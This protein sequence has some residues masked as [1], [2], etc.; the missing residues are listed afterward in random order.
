MREPDAAADHDPRWIDDQLQGAQQHRDPLARRSD[1][2][3]GPFG[4]ARRGGEDLGGR[5]WMTR[6]GCGSLD[7]PA[8]A[9]ILRGSAIA[10]LHVGDLADA[11]GNAAEQPAAGDDAAAD[12]GRDRHEHHVPA[13][14]SAEAVLAPGGRLGVVGGGDRSMEDRSQ[15]RRQRVAVR[16]GQGRGI[17]RMP[18]ALVEDAGGSDADNADAIQPGSRQLADSLHQVIRLARARRRHSPLV[19]NLG[20]SHQCCQDLGAA[21]IDGQNRLAHRPA[22]PAIAAANHE[23][24]CSGRVI[25]EPTTTAKAP[26]SSAEAACSG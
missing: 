9:V 25:A 24:M 17:E 2:R 3:L 20:A 14:A 18:A 11:A 21:D 10:R 26:A 8:G 12:A 16:N 5:A 6:P 15:P 4:T 1:D 13:F 19:Q 7:P 22:A 23:V